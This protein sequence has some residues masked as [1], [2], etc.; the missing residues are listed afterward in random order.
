MQ[1]RPG[2]TPQKQKYIADADLPHDDRPGDF[3][4]HNVIYSVAFFRAAVK[5]TETVRRCIWLWAGTGDGAGVAR[6]MPGAM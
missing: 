6:A 3:L 2:I 4:Y 5:A 1:L